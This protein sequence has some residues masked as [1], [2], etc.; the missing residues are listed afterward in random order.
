MSVDKR[1]ISVTFAWVIWFVTALFYFYEYGLRTAPAIMM[2]ELTSYFSI[3]YSGLGF[4]IGA[5]FYT[6]APMQIV[7]GALMDAY[8]GKKILPFSL[9]LCLIGS[10]LFMQQNFLVAFIGRLLIGAG[11]AFGFVGIIYIAT[12]WINSKYF[13]LVIGLTQ[14]MGMLG[15]ICGMALMARVEQ[16]QSWKAVWWYFIISGFILMVVLIF[17][18]PKRPIYLEKMYQHGRFTKVMKNLK[19][20]FSN[21]QTWFTSLYGG[22]IFIPTTVIAMLWGIPF[23]RHLYGITKI[24]AAHIMTLVFVGWIVGCPLAGRIDDKFKR[25]KLLMFVGLSVVFVLFLVIAYVP[26]SITAIIILL[27]FMGIFSSVQIIT[28]AVVKETNPDY[29]KGS[30]VGVTN[31]IVFLCSAILTPVFGVILHIFTSLYPHNDIVVNYRLSMLLI[32]IILIL[33]GIC[34]FFVKDTYGKQKIE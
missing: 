4:L 26:L 13:S 2:P 17:L 11:S 20:V 7:A 24:D 29:A 1:Q 18:I 19:I 33:A 34:L 25:H 14:A 12:N 9:F 21:S 6:Y 28:F 5:Y 32:P 30:A 8:G 16:Y 27:F 15:A 31:F 10:F 22:L 23:L 3:S